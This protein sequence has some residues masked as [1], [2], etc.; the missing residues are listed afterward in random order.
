M[1]IESPMGLIMVMTLL[2]NVRFWGSGGHPL[3]VRFLARGDIQTLSANV[4][5]WG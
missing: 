2:P 3:K 4:R 5:F 1:P